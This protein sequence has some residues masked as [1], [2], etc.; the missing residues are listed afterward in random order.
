MIKTDRQKGLWLRLL[1]A[2][3]LLFL[4]FAHRPLLSSASPEPPDL[5]AYVLP[6]GK[7][8]VICITID[9]GADKKQMPGKGEG[10]EAC[11]LAASA[12]IPARPVVPEPSLRPVRDVAPVI[13]T[14]VL[15]QRM[16]PPNAA[17]RAPPGPF[18][19]A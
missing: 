19:I 18:M 1:C 11:R 15:S 6:D 3:A 4:S 2:V 10:C 13:R 7:V 8:P 12:D 14:F 17:P 9:A 5:A 16:V